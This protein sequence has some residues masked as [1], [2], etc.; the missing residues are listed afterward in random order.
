ME[1]YFQSKNNNLFKITPYY[2][3]KQISENQE[4]MPMIRPAHLKDIHSNK[5]VPVSGVSNTKTLLCYDDDVP[6]I[7]KSD[8]IGFDNNT[9]KKNVK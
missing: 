9:E 8:F 3:F 1:I 7:Y 5:I 2:N 4:L 6:I